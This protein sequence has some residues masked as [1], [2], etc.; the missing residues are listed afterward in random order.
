[1]LAACSSQQH[2]RASNGNTTTTT[3]RPAA[4]AGNEKVLLIVLENREYGEVI[5]KAPYMTE[6]AHRYGSATQVYG[7]THPSL[8]NYL[9]LISGKT[10]GI[11]SDCTSCHV[12]GTTLADQLHSAGI[13]W[14]A[15]MES[16][17]SPCFNGASAPNGYAK[18]HNPFVY[19][20]HVVADRSLC[21]GVVPLGPELASQLTPTARSF[22]WVSPN[23]CHD[24]HDCSTTVADG[25]LRQQ[26]EPVLASPW[27]TNHATVIITFDEGTTNA[28]CCDGQAHGGHIA[29]LVLSPTMKPGS[30]LDQPVDQA[31]ILGTVEDLFGLPRLGDAVCPCAGSLL[32]LVR[33]GA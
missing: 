18:K 16:M 25:W 19:F 27:F 13:E 1:M 11:R 12:D 5:G 6:L 17:P 26:L 29:T 33:S 7:T 31:G 4:P 30:T 24:G 3:R 28:T 14:Q 21:E 22:T 20:T 32:P 8:P 23:L 10:F 2:P 9:E 15:L